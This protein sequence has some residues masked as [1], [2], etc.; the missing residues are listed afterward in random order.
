MP[1]ALTPRPGGKSR[2]PPRTAGAT[3]PRTWSEEL[4]RVTRPT[5]VRDAASR[6]SRAIELLERGDSGAAVAEATKAKS[7]SPRSASVR[8]VLGLALYGQG[9]WQEALTE[10][11]AYRRMSGRPDQNHIIADCLRA[12][13][14]PAEAVPLAEEELRA[15]APNEAKAE[16]VI[17]AASALADQ[18]RFP[19]ALAFLGRAR[20]RDD[21]AEDYTLRLWYVKG[22]I[23]A[24]AGR[25]RRGRGAVPQDHAARRRGVRRRRTPRR[26]RLSRPRRRAASRSHRL[27]QYRASPPAF[28]R[29]AADRVVA[30]QVD[31]HARVLQVLASRL[32]GEDRRRSR[33]G[34]VRDRRR[35]R[36]GRS[37][38]TRGSARARRAHPSSASAIGPEV[39]GEQGGGPRRAGCA[40][41]W[42]APARR[43]PR[44]AVA[45]VGRRPPTA[46]ASPPPRP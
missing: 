42:R 22:D 36:R 21:V 39:R 15:K 43:R 28:I 9:R 45:R 38:T 46:G 13:G 17:V 35:A 16:A 29:D 30:S 41:C 1:K 6:L 27:R 2:R 11:K 23:L 37:R 7:L 31:R 12:L 34:R 26:P 44:G 24:R 25:T 10:M 20:T 5:E 3:C 8:E 33:P 40:R 18:G 14:R 19:E 4:R 32:L